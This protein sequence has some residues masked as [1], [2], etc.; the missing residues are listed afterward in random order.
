M[1][2]IILYFQNIFRIFLLVLFYPLLICLA[3]LFGGLLL[4]LNH[5]EDGADIFKCL[6]WDV[7]KEAIQMLNWKI[8][9]QN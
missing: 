7:P 9:S 6:L 2:L 1:P 4:A 3:L 5:T 8:Q